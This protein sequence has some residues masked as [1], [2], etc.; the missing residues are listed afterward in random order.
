MIKLLEFRTCSGLRPGLKQQ[1]LDILR[2]CDDE[3]TP[4]LSQRGGLVA[5]GPG[6]GE[7]P[8]GIERYADELSTQEFILAF[9]DNILAGFMAYRTDYT[10]E[11][12]KHVLADN[13]CVYI[14]MLAVRPMYRRMGVASSLY[15]SLLAMPVYKNHAITLRTGSDNVRHHRVLERL[16]FQ[17]AARI[18][19]ERGPGVDT[20]Y[21]LHRGKRPV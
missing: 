10:P 3:V 4:P 2:G 5:M 13:K 7:R 14:N 9:D 15:R 20:M 19:N 16:D 21:Y 18:P 1:V 11:A 8:M 6:A 12:L 17:E